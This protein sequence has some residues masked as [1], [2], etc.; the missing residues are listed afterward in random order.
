MTRAATSKWAAIAARL[1][2]G[3]RGDRDIVRTLRSLRRTP[4]VAPPPCCGSG[5]A[6]RGRT[7][8]NPGFL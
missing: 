2:R 6:G 5:S 7:R 4:G 8:G 1:R 3:A